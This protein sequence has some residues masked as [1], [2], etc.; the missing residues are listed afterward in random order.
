M[1]VL[2]LSELWESK[3]VKEFGMG[4]KWWI[5]FSCRL[6]NWVLEF[7]KCCYELVEFDY[8]SVWFCGMENLGWISKVGTW[9]WILWLRGLSSL[10]WFPISPLI[11]LGSFYVIL[12]F[13]LREL[14]LFFN[15]VP[16]KV[17][18][19][20]GVVDALAIPISDPSLD[21]RFIK[22]R[23]RCCVRTWM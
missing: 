17:L 16:P 23:C 12:F 3:W 19:Q 22:R 2:D 13:K 7:L 10:S 18:D 1:C 4:G 15:V 9:D 11:S 5:K 8:H 14:Q 6:L 21:K 20:T